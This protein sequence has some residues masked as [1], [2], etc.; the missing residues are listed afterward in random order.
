[1]SVL[2]SWVFRSEFNIGHSYHAFAHFNT[3]S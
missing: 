3:A 2:I 1:M